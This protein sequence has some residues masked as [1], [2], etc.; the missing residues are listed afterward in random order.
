MIVEFRAAVVAV[1][2]DAFGSSTPI[3]DE[4]P[5]DLAQ[6]PAIVVGRVD[7][8]EG[9]ASIVADL[10]L[11]VW[12]I[13]RRVNVDAPGLQ[14]DQLADQVLST[15]NAWRSLRAYDHDL[16]LS[17]VNARTLTVGSST[18]PAYT[19]TVDTSITTC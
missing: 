15:F 4:L 1:L 6:L 5:D 7:V 14:L 17:A 16:Q 19:A 18:Y 11:D 12:L 2:V 9:D 13:G 3:F 10:S 8:S